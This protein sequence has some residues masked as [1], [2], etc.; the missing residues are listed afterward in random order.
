MEETNGEDVIMGVQDAMRSFIN[1]TGKG[2]NSG[3]TDYQQEAIYMKRYESERAEGLLQIAGIDSQAKLMESQGEDYKAFLQQNAD[4]YKRWAPYRIQDGVVVSNIDVAKAVSDRYAQELKDTQNQVKMLE[5][6]ADLATTQGKVDD[7]TL[8][9]Q[10]ENAKLISKQLMASAPQVMNARL[11]L[12]KADNK[13]VY[14][15]AAADPVKTPERNQFWQSQIDTN[16]KLTE[17]IF[18]QYG[19][20]GKTLPTED[21]GIIQPKVTPPLNSE[22]EVST[23]KTIPNYTPHGQGEA[24][25]RAIGSG[26]S[27]VAKP[28]GNAAKR[29]IQNMGAVPDALLGLVGAPPLPQLNLPSMDNVSS[30]LGSAIDTTGNAIR[31]KQSP[32]W[33][34]KVTDPMSQL[35]YKLLYSKGAGLPGAN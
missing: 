33:K 7:G 9:T 1:M 26:I 35:L 14:D 21:T 11:T 12:M 22:S 4:V 2:N 6:Q 32:V 18:S 15:A 3:M 31:D 8:A 28:V 24:M 5:T 23:P 34:E 27:A 20:P 16:D 19:A 13:A 10:V 30:A 17:S 25:R 29:T